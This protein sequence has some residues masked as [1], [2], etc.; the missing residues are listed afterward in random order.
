M[1]SSMIRYIL[2]YILKIE[3]IILIFPC[4]VA[5][6]YRE[7]E[8]FCYLGVS[9]LCL[10][11][12]FLMTIKKPANAVFYLKEGCVATSLSWIVFSLFGCLPFYLTKEIP[13]FTD[14]LFETVSGFTTTGCSILS[15]VE[16]LSHCALFWR[17]FTHWIGG[18]GVLVFLLAIIPMS[19]GSHINLMRAESTGASVGKLVPKVKYTARI[20]YLIYIGLSILQLIF[21]LAGR[22]PL[23]DA[24]NTTFATA[25]TGGFGIKNDSLASYSPYIQWITT[26]FML[27]FGISFNTYYYILYRNF[28]RAFGS[29]EVK[30]YLIIIAAATAFIF[31]NI[32]NTASGIFDT[33]T[34]ASFQVVSIMTSTG[35]STVDFDQWSQSC[36]TVLVMIM[37]IGACAG[38]TGG[39][40][41]VSRFILMVRTAIKELNSYIHPKSVMKIRVDNK[42]VEREVVRSVNVYLITFAFIFAAS[43]LIVSFDGKDLTTNFTAVTTT[44]NNIGPGLNLVGPT[45]NFGFFSPLAKFVLMFDMIAGRLELFPLLI[46]FHPAIWRDAF[47]QRLEQHRTQKRIRRQHR[48]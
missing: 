26:I 21:L 36:K 1:N 44:M 9:F 3:G 25:G 5:V 17:S 23:F 39:G 46:L 19:G 37:F 4:L 41:K 7:M 30:Y 35:F 42:P 18:M 34:K 14:A 43:T 12:G 2:G 45:Q 40:M 38:S 24:I 11:L 27:L 32:W 28:K 31:F 33:L 29:E 10:F 20:L 13:N 8:G 47:A 16:A 6:I 15:D 22:M 48:R